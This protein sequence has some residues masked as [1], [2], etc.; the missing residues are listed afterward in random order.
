MGRE[1]IAHL[2]V[3]IFTTIIVEKAQSYR[4]A[5]GDWPTCGALRVLL[6]EDPT[7]RLLGTK[8]EEYL[9]HHLQVGVLRCRLGFAA[10]EVNWDIRLGELLKHVAHTRIKPLT[11]FLPWA[12]EQ[13]ESYSRAQPHHRHRVLEEM[14][15]RLERCLDALGSGTAADHSPVKKAPSL[16][17]SLVGR[18]QLLYEDTTAA[19]AISLS[20]Q[21]LQPALERFA[22]WVSCTRHLSP[23]R[24]LYSRMRTF[25]DRHYSAT[26][27]IPLL[28]FHQEF[29]LPHLE[30][31]EP[32][33]DAETELTRQLD[34][35]RRELTALLRRRWATDRT[36]NEIALTSEELAQV[37]GTILPLVDRDNVAASVSCRCHLAESDRIV[38][39]NGTY[40]AGFGR[41]FSR[42]LH[43]IDPAVTSALKDRNRSLP[44]TCLA[45]I[46][47]DDNFNGNLHPQL[48]DYVI[49]LPSSAHAVRP[50]C[51]IPVEE[52]WVT[53]TPGDPHSLR[54]MWTGSDQEVVPIDLGFLVHRA[55]PPLHQLLNWFSPVAGFS[56]ILPTSLS[57]GAEEESGGVLY[58]PRYTYR[59]RLVLSR[60]TW[61]V[62]RHALPI[63]DQKE[64][65]AEYFD[66]LLRWATAHSMPSQMF[67][68][69]AVAGPDAPSA[70]IDPRVARLHV[71]QLLDMHNG[72]LVRY[73]RQALEEVS[74]S[75]DPFR[76]ELEERLPA[77]QDLLVLDGKRHV[78]EMILQME[79]SH[80]LERSRPDILS[81][82]VS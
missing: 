67:Y 8:L 28:R 1:T 41:L 69:I 33:L 6:E 20:S 34:A 31:A 16:Q 7:G 39:S 14:E 10:Q 32:R 60:R 49:S 81:A 37:C 38:I 82:P 18:S 78:A 52:L 3:S 26:R 47:G 5:H 17:S 54:L 77:P 30:T 25:F 80:F 43:I 11:E 48:F 76:L 74:R 50:E 51:Q 4:H 23:Q 66:R 22:E 71:P 59:E 13:V 44:G 46:G 35:G 61:L 72:L 42:F 24:D 63:G 19:L 2:P 73:W 56:L 58:R 36:T 9:T 79:P 53:P 29:Y 15:T 12:R 57:G 64:S 55:R 68:R 45:Q 70:S 21:Q 40:T 75:N 65:D 27:A 62:G